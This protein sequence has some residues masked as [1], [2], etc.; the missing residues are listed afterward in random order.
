MGRAIPSNRV[1]RTLV[2]LGC[3]ITMFLVVVPPVAATH[4][5]S[6]QSI[7]ITDDCLENQAFVDGDPTVVADRLP[8]RYTA[9]QNASSGQPLLFVRALRCNL[10]GFDS[11]VTFGSFGIVVESPDGTHCGPSTPIDVPP[12]CNWYVLSWVANDLELV[13]WLR[14][15]SPHFPVTYVRDLVFEQGQADP[16]EGGVPFHF[17][18]SHPAPSPFSIDAVGRERPGELRVRGAYWSEVQEGTVRVGFS[19][20]NLISGDA[21]GVVTAA[22]KSELARLMG[23]EQRPYT[24]GYSAIGAERWQHAFYRKQ[25]LG[26]PPPNATSFAGSCSAEGTVYFDPAV[27]YASQA[28]TYEYEAKAI[29]NGTL[30]GTEVSDVRVTMHQGGHSQGSCARAATTSPGPGEITFPTGETLSYNIDFTSVDGQIDIMM[31][32]SRSGRAPADGTFRTP[33]TP[34]DTLVRCGTTGVK[35]IP[36]DMTFT[37]DSPLVSEKK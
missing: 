10:Q 7:V 8:A 16:S 1:S 3:T 30:N 20:D 34:P 25:I 21:T 29:C 6:S 5:P 2:A 28:L 12:V 24:L 19:T 22:P 4:E 37:T 33:R 32:G 9:V 17:E 18:A 31:Y 26:P 23:R 36:M 14:D 35:E 15:G 13:K 11:P 27:T